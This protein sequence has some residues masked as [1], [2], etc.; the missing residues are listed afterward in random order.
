MLNAHLLSTLR[1]GAQDD[2]GGTLV[3]TALT[4]LILIGL[5]FAV[6]E[7]SLAVYSY[8]YV[9]NAAHEA[10]RYAIVRGGSWTQTCDGT[11]TAG[12]GSGNSMC[13]ASAQD[14]ENYAATRGYPAIAIDPTDVCVTYYGSTS[15]P[16]TPSTACYPSTSPNSPGDIVQVTI[17]YPYSFALPGIGSYTY[18]LTSTSLMVIAQ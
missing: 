6:I 13:V 16:T 9:A 4:M 12:S 11:G 3:E 10:T 1:H 18:N 15:L 17:S 5:L 14:I 8:H 2:Q 7:G